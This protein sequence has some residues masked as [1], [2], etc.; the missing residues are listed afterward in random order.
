MMTKINN[1][2]NTIHQ[3]DCLEVLDSLEKGSV[4]LAYLDPPFFTEKR[5][6]LKTRDRTKEFC[7]DDLWGSEATYRQFLFECIYKVKAVLKKTSTIFVHCDNNTNHII[8]S[9]LDKVFGANNFR[10]EIIWYYKR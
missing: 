3:G 10:S 1:L 6:S 8:R 9:I 5:H 4:D 2:V 7:F